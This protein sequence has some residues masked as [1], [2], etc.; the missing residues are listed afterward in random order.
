LSVP[1]RAHQHVVIQTSARLRRCKRAEGCC[2]S[3][4]EGL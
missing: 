2:V 3:L 1:F 4:T